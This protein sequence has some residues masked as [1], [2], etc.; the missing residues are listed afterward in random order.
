M[1]CVSEFTLNEED[2]AALL[3]T[4]QRFGA[5][6]LAAATARP[7]QPMSAATQRDLL[8]QLQELGVLN[9]GPEPACAIWDDPLD[10]QQ[11]RFA[12]ESLQLLARYSPAFAWQV[13]LQAQANL[14]NRLHGCSGGDD[15]VCFDG[16]LSMGQQALV[17][18]LAGQSLDSDQMAQ[19]ADCWQTPTTATERLLHALPDWDAVWL[20]RWEPTMGLH[21]LRLPRA[22][23]DLQLQPAGHGFDELPPQLL[24][25]H[26]GKAPALVTDKHMR[27]SLILLLALHGMGLLA[28]A[29]GTVQAA[30]ARAAEFARMRRQG[31]LPIVKHPAVQQLL[32]SAS[33][34]TW[35][36]EASLQRLWRQTPD[37]SLLVEV[38]RARAQLHPLLCQAASSALQ[39][40]G[41][42][43]YMRDTG[44]EKALRDCNQAR[45]LAG[46]PTELTLA[47]AEWEKWQ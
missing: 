27:E 23:V 19:L 15:V 41:G 36:G 16:R 31:G 9:H 14:L 47:C 11:R 10:P 2:L 18:E 35:L 20:P 34:A 1:D 22:E 13:H 39:V 32:A 24:A 30:Q 25:L 37:L 46:S 4:M 17:R 42:M 44:A 43:G 33:H 26:D 45:L 5:R 12:L 8:C 21:W 38:W 6:T 7:E 40:F 29:C 3:E 28:I